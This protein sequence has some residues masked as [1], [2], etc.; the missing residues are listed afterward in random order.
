MQAVEAKAT[1]MPEER[2]DGLGHIREMQG[3]VFFF[4]LLQKIRVE[5]DDC[6]K[7]LHFL[8]M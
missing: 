4:V 2:R 3:K 1:R 6:Y 7:S 5:L 8:Q